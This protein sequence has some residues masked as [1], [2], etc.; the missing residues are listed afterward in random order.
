MYPSTLFM[1]GKLALG[2]GAAEV[3]TDAW[4]AASVR[5]AARGTLGVAAFS[6]SSCPVRSAP[7]S[8]RQLI[9]KRAAG[10]AR[11]TLPLGR[12]IGANRCSGGAGAKNPRT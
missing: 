11:N 6:A 3:P 9:A 10:S 4:T 2:E 7:R 8:A 1:P 12:V 5:P